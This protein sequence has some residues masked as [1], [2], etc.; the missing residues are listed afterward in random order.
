MSTFGEIRFLI[1]KQAPG[2]D[3]DVLDGFI[4]DRYTQILDELDWQRLDVR[5]VIQTVAVYETGTLTA[6]NASTTITG[7]GTTWTTGMT[8][9]RIRIGSDPAFYTFTYVSATSGTLDRTYEGDTATGASYKI[10]QNTFTVPSDRARVI[11]ALTLLEP[12]TPLQRMSRLEL[13]RI[14]PSLPAF[15]DPVLWV[16]YLDDGST[17]PQPRFELYPIPEDVLAIEALYT[18]DQSALA[19]GDTAVTLL[20]WTRPGC[21]KAGVMADVRRLAEDYV[22]ALSYEA[23]FDELLGQMVNVESRRKGPAKI[24]MASRFVRHRLGRALNS[25]P[26]GSRVLP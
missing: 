23:Q 5:S 21:L 18:A 16:P 24:R 25:R 8:G 19:A 12:A 1:S 4:N 9:R 6:T 26:G 11:Q 13:K 2:V 22:G 15:G 20:P 7:S 17:P 10:F 14:A 3:P